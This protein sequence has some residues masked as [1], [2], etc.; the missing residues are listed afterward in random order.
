MPVLTQAVV[1][2]IEITLFENAIY[3]LNN[4]TC[5][6]TTLLSQHGMK[7]MDT[8]ANKQRFAVTGT[9]GSP[10][11]FV[12]DTLPSEFD[13]CD[14][15][16]TWAFAEVDLKWQVGPTRVRYDLLMLKQGYMGDP[17]QETIDGLQKDLRFEVERTLCAG[18][19]DAVIANLT[20]NVTDNGNG[21]FTYLVANYG[22]RAG[23]QLGQLMDAML[24][25]G[26]PVQAATS[27]G[28]APGSLAPFYIRS[29][30]STLGS[31]S[32]T[33]N[34][35]ITGLGGGGGPLTGW[36]FYRSRPSTGG[37]ISATDAP[38]GIEYL[39]SDFTDFAMFQSTTAVTAPRFKA[40]IVNRGGA[41]M[42]IDET[43]L[44]RMLS[45]G[46]VS[47]PADP[48]DGEGPVLDGFFLMHT[49]NVNAFAM[50]MLQ[51]RRFMNLRSAGAAGYAKK[52]LTFCDL[53]VVGGH[54]AQRNTV[55][56]PLA[57]NLYVRKN[58]PMWGKFMALSGQTRFSIPC[59]PDQEIRWVRCAQNA[60]HVR[61]GMVRADNCIAAI[62]DA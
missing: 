59:S 29:V 44:N 53:P 36:V 50:T 54:L 34:G 7:E 14:D 26:T 21:T 47:L 57:R 11:R 49:F 37:V 4:R 61:P 60:A 30:V 43:L 45:L 1:Q 12:G 6:V 28:A 46:E 52:Y 18:V 17:V 35:D 40:A 48:G 23:E 8:S 32:I 38:Y 55:Y 41:P 13:N 58:G 22:G 51:D 2:P 56:Y 15:S 24:L 62:P 3:N 33:T 10:T 9:T 25:E 19:G 39:I 42:A 27:V 16:P 31:E 20:G 5:E